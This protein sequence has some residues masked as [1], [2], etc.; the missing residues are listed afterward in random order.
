MWDGVIYEQQAKCPNVCFGLRTPQ[1]PQFH[2]DNTNRG[3]SSFIGPESLNVSLLWKSVSAV[4]LVFDNVLPVISTPVMGMQDIVVYADQQSNLY[5]LN[6]STGQT[7]WTTPLGGV[8]RSSPVVHDATALVFV[9][10][11]QPSILHAIN[12]ATGAVK[13]VN[14][15]SGD[16]VSSPV[17]DTDSVYCGTS[18]GFM[19]AFNAANGAQ[20][21]SYTTD[22]ASPSDMFGAA[23]INSPTIE[24]VNRSLLF[25][26]VDNQIHR[27]DA[28]SGLRS[29][30]CNRHEV[31]GPASIIIQDNVIFATS[32]SGRLTAMTTDTCDPLFSFQLEDVTIAGTPT[33]A[34]NMLYFGASDGYVYGI[35]A[36]SG[37]IIWAYATFGIF[38]TSVTYAADKTLYVGAWCAP[39]QSCVIALDSVTGAQVWTYA[40]SSMSDVAVL[41][42]VAVGADGMLKYC[43]CISAYKRTPHTSVV[44]LLRFSVHWK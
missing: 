41:S 22:L 17:A 15:V 5:A 40:Y 19:F 26:T 18:N 33:F 34:D 35:D 16:I 42:S 3:V 1:W 21:W 11:L 24:P 30:S 38:S 7:I 6:Q 2:G 13:W 27:L 23:V 32:A 10:T 37:A 9:A 4:D 20:L 28:L 31:A 44:V 12:L 39:G 8:V 29:W 14:E 25:V 36:S 43:V